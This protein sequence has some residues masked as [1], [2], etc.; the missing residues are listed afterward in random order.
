MKEGLAKY[1]SYPRYMPSGVGWI[2][3]IPEK[4]EVKRLRFTVK[5]NLQT[6]SDNCTDPN[7]EI[8]YLDIGN[9]DGDGNIISTENL[10]FRDAPSRARRIVENGNT[11]ISTVRTYLKAIAFLEKIPDNMIASTGFAVIQPQRATMPKYLFYFFRSQYFVE[12]VVMNSKGVSYPAITPSQSPFNLIDIP[13]ILA[14][15]HEQQT[16]SDFLDRETT[17]INTIIEKQNH[18]IELLKEKRSALITQAV[19]KGLDPNVKMKPSGVDWIGE[20]PDVWEV[21]R[22]KYIAFL[23]SGENITSESITENDVYPVYGGN[24]LRGFYSRYTHSG[25]HI[26]IGRQGALCGN[27]NYA[28]GNFWASEHAVVVSKIDSYETFWLGELLRIM[29]LNQYSVSAAQP[30]LSVDKIKNLFIPIPPLTE[31]Q[32]IADFLRGETEKINTLISKIQRQID[33][34][35]EYKQ[36]LITAAVTGKIDVRDSTYATNP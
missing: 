26:L 30:G 24:G 23:K 7:Y 17:R 25:R 19:T 14:P 35:N 29:N 10:L 5:Y 27:I 31:Q 33:L 32:A 34:L 8:E 16:I 2:G 11:I 12:Q 21:R 13:I 20:I 18:L 4:W 28:E 1:Q 15:Y 9:V 3:D 6:L 22:L 36:S